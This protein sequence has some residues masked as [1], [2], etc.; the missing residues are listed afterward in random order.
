MAG[1]TV[2]LVNYYPSQG[3]LTLSGQVSVG[4]TFSLNDGAVIDGQTN[5]TLI[6][7][8]VALRS[9]SQL[10][11]YGQNHSDYEVNDLSLPYQGVNSL[12]AEV[13]DSAGSVGF[14]PPLVFTAQLNDL[15]FGSVAQSYV[16]GFTYGPVI[17]QEVDAGSQLY[18]LYE[19]ILGRAPDPFGY[20]TFNDTLTA[21]TENHPLPPDFAVAQALLSSPEYTADFGAAASLSPTAF[22]TDLYETALHRAPDPAGLQADVNAL[23]AGVSQAQVAAQV[24][25]SPE[26]IGPVSPAFTNG[27]GVF[28]MSAFDA[29]VARLYYGLL[30]RTPDAAGLKGW[31]TFGTTSNPLSPISTLSTITAGIL[32]S[33][34]YLAN[35]GG[36]SNAQFIDAIYQNALGRAPDAGGLQNDLTALNAGASR[37][38]VALGITESPEAAQYLAP[39]IEYGFKLA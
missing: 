31:E 4:V 15:L 30:D 33:P 36:L 5:L 20:E 19:A 10:F 6:D 25:L 21:G 26:A 32:Q 22:V 17:G 18:S 39:N 13:T 23:N 11:P 35:S 16:A 28:E 38:S 3:S 34:E 27:P 2:S 37:A 14:S 12:T 8:G 7:N 1:I 9:L 24:A 29:S